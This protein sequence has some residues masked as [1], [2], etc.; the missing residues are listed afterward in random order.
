ML[1]SAWCSCASPDCRGRSSEAQTEIETTQQLTRYQTIFSVQNPAYTYA[2]AVTH[3]V[4]VVLQCTVNAI[5]FLIWLDNSCSLGQLTFNSVVS[6]S[7]SLTFVCASSMA[8]SAELTQSITIP[9]HRKSVTHM[10]NDYRPAAKA[11]M[12]DTCMTA[13]AQLPCCLQ[14]DTLLHQLHCCSFLTR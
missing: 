4:H 11:C 10:H 2:N 1:S 13:A 12:P 8:L 7:M 9:I 14:F 5:D 3:A 6:Q